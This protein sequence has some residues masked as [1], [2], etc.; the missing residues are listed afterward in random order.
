MGV[1]ERLMNYNL[2]KVVMAAETE[3]WNICQMPEVKE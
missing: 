3:K 1:G 2:M